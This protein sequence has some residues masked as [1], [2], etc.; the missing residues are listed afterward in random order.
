MDQQ[1]DVS[2][3]EL[4]DTDDLAVVLPPPP[5]PDDT[6]PED[7]GIPERRELRRSERTRGHPDRYTPG[8]Y[9]LQTEK[10]TRTAVRSDWL[11]RASFLLLLVEQHG[12]VEMPNFIGEAIMKICTGMSR[13]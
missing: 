13:T 9:V 2:D 11:Q 1:A 12:L 5:L 6:F 4:E 8:N 7:A 10:Y 3:T